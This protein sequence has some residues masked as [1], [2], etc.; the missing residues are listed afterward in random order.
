[1]EKTTPPQNFANHVRYVPLYH[2]YLSGIIVLTLIGSMVNLFK[3][4]G[5]SNIYSASL[6]VVIM[7]CLLLLFWYSRAFALK[8]Q[9]RA[10]RSEENLRHFQMTGK[11][12]DSR[13]TM[14][15]IVALR[16]AS[17]EEFL[18][19]A[20]RAVEENMKPIDIKKAVKNWRAD[21]YRA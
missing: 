4:I 17:D 14:G 20:K 7:V 2:F 19:L 3:S 15:Q 18:P 13:L 9:D 8:A 5:T 12:F 16:F 6:I 10:I 21:Y 11:L 1:M